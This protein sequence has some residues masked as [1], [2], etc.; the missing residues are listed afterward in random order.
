MNI[1]YMSKNVNTPH[2]NSRSFFPSTKKSPTIEV[3]AKAMI[4][5]NHKIAMRILA[6]LKDCIFVLRGKVAI[7]HIVQVVRKLLR[8]SYDNAFSSFISASPSMLS[9]DS[10][11]SINLKV[12]DLLNYNN[13]V[14]AFSLPWKKTVQS[15]FEVN[16]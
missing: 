10:V 16:K 13:L 7:S 15:S 4:S 14:L 1:E 9:Q 11:Q 3:Y 12:R 5:T 6:I 8:I 2:G